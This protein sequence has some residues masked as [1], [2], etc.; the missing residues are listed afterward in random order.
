M[1]KSNSALTGA[2]LFASAF[3]RHGVKCVFGQ[4]IPSA[5]FLAAPEFGIRQLGYRTENAGAAMA[6]AYARISGHVAVVAAQNG[7]AAT[8]LVPGLAEAFKASIPVVALVQDVHRAQVDK[9]AFQELDHLDLFRGCTKWIR[10]VASADR[11]DD[12]VDMAFTVASS[13][14]PGP[15]VLLAPFDLFEDV[16]LQSARTAQ[17]GQFPL[18]RPV[19]D[20]AQIQRAAAL[21]CEAKRPLVVAGGGVHSSQ[22]CAELAALQ[23]TASLPIATTT[24]GKGAVDERHP[25]SV[26]IIGYFMG[27]RGMAK[28][29][30]HM[31][32]DAD[33]VLLIGT[34][35][36]QN[37]TDSWTLFR[38]GK[39]FIHL[40]IDPA[41]I[42]RNYEALRLLG[43]AKTTLA[44]L[45]QA[46]TAHG[47]KTRS[48]GR[49]GF[50][51][52]IAAGRELHAAEAAGVVRSAA[53]PIRPERIMGELQ[54]VLTDR[55]IV[56]SDASYASIWT[57][58]Y[59]TSQKAGGRFLAPRGLAGLGWGLPFALGAKAAAPDSPVICVAGDGGFA[60]VWSELETSRRLDLPVTIVILNNQILGYQL[61]AETLLFG[62]YTDVCNFQPVD[63]AAIARA[64]GCEGIRIEE[65]DQLLP[66]IKQALASPVTTL[67]DV[68]TDPNAFPPVT[69]FDKLK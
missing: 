55:T 38:P 6:D 34:R 21:L 42:G 45:T 22:A 66:A 60:H 39:T 68:V 41:E 67:L 20:P 15:V 58:N 26:G 52:A 8:L 4:S 11:I 13:G 35:T 28:G 63:H 29:M 37:G 50:E 59:L 16:A 10:R 24:M 14:R 1:N 40:D 9:N 47:L 31:V 19:A 57:S 46:M 53:T 33:V 56:V 32:D 43:D 17:M 61:H 44:A 64:C 48:A 49:A 3:R 18:D 51:A 54:S 23:E 7:P 2:Q 30:R 36:N 27:Q 25:L 12:Y 69:A 5:F 65:P 62:K